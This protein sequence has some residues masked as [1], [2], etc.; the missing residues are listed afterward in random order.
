LDAAFVAVLV[1]DFVAVFAAF[2]GALRAASFFGAGLAAD[3]GAGLG[4]ALRAPVVLAGL[5]VRAEAPDLGVD[6][7]AAFLAVDF[8]TAL[9]VGGLAGTN[10]LSVWLMGKVILGATKAVPVNSRAPPL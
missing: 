5:A 3:F 1:A 2:A 9:L 10:Y 4:A 8:A 7:L 6:L